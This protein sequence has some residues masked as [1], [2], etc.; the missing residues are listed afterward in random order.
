M[1]PLASGVSGGLT[2]ARQ[3]TVELT[4]G[5]EQRQHCLECI[6]EIVTRGLSER[7]QVMRNRGCLTASFARP[8]LLHEGLTERLPA[9]MVLHDTRQHPCRVCSAVIVHLLECLPGLAVGDV[10]P[11]I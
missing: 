2:H 3:K 4:D 10:S 9:L 11:V 8:R 1:R 5:N 6:R 7:R